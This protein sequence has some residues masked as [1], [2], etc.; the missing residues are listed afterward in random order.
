M[1]IIR[2]DAVPPLTPLP[3]G[4]SMRWLCGPEQ[5]DTLDVGL[6][7]FEPG[8]AT[9]DRRH[10][11]GHRAR[12]K[13]RATTNSRGRGLLACE[14]LARPAAPVTCTGRSAFAGRST[15]TGRAM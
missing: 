12:T 15:F 6:V 7:R 2:A 3:N 1:D 8:T 9:P 13:L 14:G 11:T 10:R 5:D 4:M